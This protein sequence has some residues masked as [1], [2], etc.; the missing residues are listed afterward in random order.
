MPLFTVAQPKTEKTYAVQETGLSGILTLPDLTEFFAVKYSDNTYKECNTDNARLKVP[1]GSNFK[2]QKCSTGGGKGSIIKIAS[3]NLK[4]KDLESI[5]RTTAPEN[6]IQTPDS[7]IIKSNQGI[8][9]LPAG[10]AGPMVAYIDNYKK[11]SFSIIHPE[12]QELAAAV[13]ASYTDI[14]FDFDSY[15]LRTSTYPTL[16]YISADLRTNSA[17]TI[18]IDGYASSEGTAAYNMLLSK[19]RANSVK[20]YLVNS[21]VEA[22]RLKIKAFGETNPIASNSTEEGRVLNR[23]VEFKH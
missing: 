7:I 13:P 9:K 1:A 20:T 5:I 19:S 11:S 18:E 23:R 17:K 10:D 3:T 16:D 12:R 15:V 14:R 4:F 22:S 6:I 8:L 21:G 2:P